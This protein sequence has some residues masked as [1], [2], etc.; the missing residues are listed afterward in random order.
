MIPALAIAAYAYLLKENHRLMSKTDCQYALPLGTLVQEYQVG[1]VIGVGGF[2]IVY[3][4]KNKYFDEM[5]ALKEF[6]PIDLACRKDNTTVVPLSADTQSTYQWTLKKFLEEARTLRELAQPVPHK[7]IVRV[8]QFIE[9]NGTAY[10]VMDFEEGRPLAEIFKEKGV[11]PEQE[12][13]RILDPLLEGLERVHHANILHRDIKPSNILIRSDLSP[14]LIDFGSARRMLDDKSRSII[15]T[16]TPAYAAP[17]QF[18][19][20]GNHGPWTDIYSLGATLYCAVTGT[21]P[22]NAV[23]RLQGTGNKPAAFLA[24]DANSRPFL[25][26]IDAALELNAGERPQSIAEWRKLFNADTQTVSKAD[27]DRTILYP[28][29]KDSKAT[30]I[31]SP[32]FKQPAEQHPDETIHP[33]V[34][35]EK[36]KRLSRILISGG[37]LALTCIAAIIFLLRWTDILDVEPQQDATRIASTSAEKAPHTIQDADSGDESIG[38][39]PSPPDM[40]RLFVE[41]DPPESRVRNLSIRPRFQQGMELKPGPHRIEVSAQGFKTH[42]HTIDIRAG[43]TETL[44]VVLEKNPTITNRLG[45]TFVWIEPGDF[46]M[47]TPKV[48]AYRDEDEIHHRVAVEP[49][50]FMQTTEVTVGQFKAFIKETGYRT[51][52]ETMGGSFIYTPQGKWV[53]KKAVQWNRPQYAT[54]AENDLSDNL[55]VTC[56]TWN[57]AQA[58][59]QWLRKKEGRAYDLPTEAQWEYACRAGSKTPFSFGGC[60]SI[61][62]ANF[63]GVGSHFGAC[64]SKVETTHNGPLTVA[65]L[66]ANAWGLFDLHGNVAEWCRDWYGAYQPGATDASEE[67]S[68]GMERVVR[69]GHFLAKANQCR[70]AKRSQFLP[71][72]AS[73]VIGFRLVTE[74]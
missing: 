8:Q 21:E 7:S 24:S 60:L 13:R 19:G 28:I 30:V 44:H 31:E 3:A 16:M 14:V 69:G 70:S 5:V 37:I 64:P 27:D 62:Q 23:D 74:K 57:D 25:R 41:T 1:E 63:G 67:L 11:L 51:Q 15:S 34:P 53:K 42:T 39:K 2:G 22:T 10:M 48:K 29:E 12:L 72:A 56:V 4:A 73:Q 71:D 18:Y 38:P 17:E 59:V 36:P 50:F 55:P 32:D 66:E 45:M 33:E 52:A 49:G 6:L 54:I 35:E 65:K 9:A 20:S 47:G 61:S 58:F 43:E 46:L 68:L 40:G 26:A